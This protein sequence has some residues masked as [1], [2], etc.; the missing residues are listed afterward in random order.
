MRIL[1]LG[2]TLFVGRAVVR[3]ALTRGH[4]VTLFNR[5][6][7]NPELFPEA[8]HLRGD[9]DG[10]VSALEGRSWDCVVDV[11]ARIPRHVRSTAEVLAGNVGH[12]TYVS[13]ASVYADH[14][15]PGLREDAPLAELE[16][17]STE[18]MEHYG[19]LKAACER[20]AE[21]AFPGRVLHLRAGLIVGPND[22]TG[23]FTY[24]P[25]RIA[26]GGT[27]L[28]PEPRDQPVQFI[29]VR[30]LAGWAL[31]MAER[32][33]TGPYNTVGPAEPLTMKGFL[34]GARDSL[35]AEA[36]FE[37]VGE[38]FLYEREV[39][40]WMDLPLWLAPSHE[41]EL[42]GLLSLDVS[43]ALGDGL[44]FRPLEETVRETLAHAATT[45][46]AGLEPDRERR[47]LEEW[48]GFGG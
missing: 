39:G 28:A 46:D 37:W 7:T 3:E 11:P 22:P 34:E 35:G 4:Q 32:G 33:A 1:V 9:R 44:T 5:G 21:E 24:W 47:L 15:R 16:D 36:T 19:G 30:G 2:G 27:V 26:R 18:D 13:T 40:A 38:D 14:S 23:R 25:H 48:A 29:D 43:K 41:P 45:G 17:P 8:E 31:D 12:Y 20:V 42:A 6:R 10:D